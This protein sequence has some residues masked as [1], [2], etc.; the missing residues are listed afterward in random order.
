M[1]YYNTTKEKGNTLK[2]NE[3][4]AATQNQRVYELYKKYNKLSPS[5]AWQLYGSPDTPLTSIRRSINTLTR[6]GK[7]M[8]TMNK[9]SGIYGRNEFIWKLNIN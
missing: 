8:K 3:S 5:A 4:K 2:N 9:V 7:L 6:E 1:T